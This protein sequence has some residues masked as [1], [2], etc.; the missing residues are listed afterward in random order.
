MKLLNSHK[1]KY[2]AK[3]KPFVEYILMNL[4]FK[5][6]LFVDHHDHHFCLQKKNDIIRIMMV[7][8]FLILLKNIYIKQKL[9]TVEG[10]SARCIYR[11]I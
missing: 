7:F 6:K 2:I 1:K 9:V 11:N 4:K 8:F 10:A 5:I 3:N